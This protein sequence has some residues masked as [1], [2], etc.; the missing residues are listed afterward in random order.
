[1]E[2]FIVE[3]KRYLGFDAQDAE[4]LRRLGPR[5]EKYLPEMAE[6]FYSTIAQH[7]NAA[8]V[9][10]GGETQI[11]RL[12]QTLQEWARGLFG[13]VYDESYAV[14]RFQIGY[15]HVRIGLDQ[16]YVISAMGRVRMFLQDSLLWEVPASEERLPYARTLSKALDL[17]L[18]LMCE[19]YMQATVENL[20][21]L[22]EQLER[23]NRELAKASRAKDEFL[24]HVSHEL[25]TPLNSILGFSKMILDGLCTGPEEQQELLRD[26]FSSAQH[27][28]GLVNDILDIRRI[29]EGRMS[30]RIESVSL[31]ELLDSTVPLVAVH[32]A[33]KG[34]RLINETT[35]GPLPAVWA[36]EMRLRQ[37]LLNLFTNAVKFT[38]EGSVTIRVRMPEAPGERKDALVGLVRVEIEDTGFGI[39]SEERDAAFEPFVQLNEVEAQKFGGAGLGLAISRRLVELM[40]GQIGLESGRQGRGTLAWLTIPVAEAAAPKTSGSARVGR[41]PG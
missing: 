34:L 21:R 24:S 30:L 40:G 37:V 33:E 20:R 41:V 32:A 3:I 10:T 9:F 22:N 11:A 39:S 13:G 18:N 5:L 16:K 19:S 15:R 31:R 27:L 38:R 35:N 7:P 29:E 1:M 14:E 28:L 26:V 6:Q 17:D 25:R 2:N 8:R 12:K 36:D 4:L 23:L